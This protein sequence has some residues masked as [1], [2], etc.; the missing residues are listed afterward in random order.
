MGGLADGISKSAQSAVGAAAKVASDINKSLRAVSAMV[1]A[2]STAVANLEKGICQSGRSVL[3]PP[4]MRR[5]I[6]LAGSRAS[7]DRIAKGPWVPE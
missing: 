3:Q 7:V 1:G 5:Q 4:G 6:P 2:V